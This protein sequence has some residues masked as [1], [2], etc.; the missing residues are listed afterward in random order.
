MKKADNLLASI[1]QSKQQPLARLLT[2]LGIR[3]VG[4]VMA[5]DLTRHYSDLDQ[6]LT[7]DKQRSADN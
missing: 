2:A 7:S 1:Q 4:E 5:G 3:G 6:L